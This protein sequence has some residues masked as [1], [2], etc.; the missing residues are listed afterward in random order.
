MSGSYQFRNVRFLGYGRGR[1]FF[2]PQFK[3]FLPRMIRRRFGSALPEQDFGC[4]VGLDRPMGN[5]VISKA[6]SLMR[7]PYRPI[8][9]LFHR[10]PGCPDVVLDLIAL[11]V[12]GYGEIISQGPL[13]LNTDRETGGTGDRGR[14]GSSLLLTHLEGC[15]IFPPCHVPFALNIPAPTITS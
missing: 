1:L 8:Q 11:A 7:D 15:V 13:G 4:F 5:R 3:G 10:H 12:I 9:P 14:Q 6:L 2:L